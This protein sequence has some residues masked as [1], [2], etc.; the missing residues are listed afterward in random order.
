MIVASRGAI[1]AAICDISVT[2]GKRNITARVLHFGLIVVLALDASRIPPLLFIPNISD[3]H[4]KVGDAIEIFGLNYQHQL[5]Q[6]RTEISAISAIACG[7]HHPPSWRIINTEGYSLLDCPST[8]GGV[9]ID[10]TDDS[11]V[12]FW[13]PTEGTYYT[14]LDFRYYIHPI[15]ESL[16]AGEEVKRWCSGWEFGYIHIVRAMDLGMPEHHAARIDT[17]AKSIGVGPQAVWVSHKLHQS[18]PDLNVG[19]FILEIDGETVGR[20]ADMRRLSEAETRKVLIL[21]NRQ[22]ME[23]LVHA[24][25]LPLQGISR[26][27]CWA[28]AILQQSPP[29]ALEQA[30]TEFMR[31]AE[32][33]G[34]TDPDDLVYISSIY[35]GSPSHSVLSPTIWILEIAEYK[36]RRLDDLIDIIT[37]LKGRGKSEEYIRVKLMGRDGST[38]IVGL[39]LNSHFW[40]AWMLGRKGDKWV[41]QELE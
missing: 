40:P 32:M 22:E 19:D 13:M 24:K 5:M 6:R 1:P 38:G 18:S 28:G 37:S 34:V 20:M 3:K 7:R 29:S 8:L 41:R 16:R 27:I 33:E 10:P 39:K 21:R 17:I 35:N 36:V 30:N 23:V 31:V 2:I 9:L 11:L 15:I 14:G 4:Y 12:A 25:Q 26:I